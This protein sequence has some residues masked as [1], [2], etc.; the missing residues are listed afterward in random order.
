[1]QFITVS[2]NIGKD[3]ALRQTQ[4]GD[5]VLGFN[6]GVKQGYGDRS[7]TNWYRVSVWGKR[8]ESLSRFLRKGTKVVVAGE[9]SI[10]EYESKPQYDIRA[11]EVEF[12]A[13]REAGGGGDGFDSPTQRATQQSP[14]YADDLDDDVPF[15]TSDV[16]AELRAS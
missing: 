14:G 6:V 16:R 3:P 5:Q 9:L 8:A 12:M 13:P 4:S 15:L 10:G 7:S 1:M 11:N 2:G